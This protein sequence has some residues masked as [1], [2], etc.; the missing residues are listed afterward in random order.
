MSCVEIT[1]INVYLANGYVEPVVLEIVG[2]V[3][4]GTLLLTIGMVF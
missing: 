4:I 1:I 2:C 3:A